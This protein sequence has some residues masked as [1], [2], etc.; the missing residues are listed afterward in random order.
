MENWKNLLYKMSRCAFAHLHEHGTLPISNCESRK[1]TCR[2]LLASGAKQKLVQYSA[3]IEES[4]AV[5]LRFLMRPSI[6]AAAIAGRSDCR[7]HAAF[8]AE[9]VVLRRNKSVFIRCPPQTQR[10]AFTAWCKGDTV[11]AGLDAHVQLRA[12]DQA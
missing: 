9:A 6:A 1:M 3:A 5:E 11:T 8:V 10:S 4:A 2:S 7:S 12:R